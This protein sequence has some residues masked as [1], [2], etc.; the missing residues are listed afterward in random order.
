LHRTLSREDSEEIGKGINTVSNDQ[1]NGYDNGFGSGLD[2]LRA[3]PVN[4]LGHGA[5]WL[6]RAGHVRA[7]RPAGP[8][9]GFGPI[10]GF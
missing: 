9:R 8:R 1:L 3:A 2:P 6:G 10:V 5:G 7:V 4:P